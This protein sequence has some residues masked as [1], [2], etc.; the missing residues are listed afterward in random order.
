MV[1]SVLIF[2]IAILGLIM[3]VGGIWGFVILRDQTAWKRLPMRYYGMTVAM[4]CGGFAMWGIA[5]GLRL[6]LLILANAPP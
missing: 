3:I 6:L 2:L 5:Q 1:T 4:I